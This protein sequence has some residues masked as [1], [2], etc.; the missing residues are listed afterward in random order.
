LEV[1]SLDGKL[2]H[3]E[4]LNIAAGTSRT[5]IDLSDL[6]SGTYMLNLLAGEASVSMGVKVE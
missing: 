1:Y 3:R 6:R 4:V 5:T 2:V